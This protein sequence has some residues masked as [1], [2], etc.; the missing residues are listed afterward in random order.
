MIWILYGIQKMRY[1][2]KEISFI[3]LLILFIIFAIWNQQKNNYEIS[4]FNKETDTYNNFQNQNNLYFETLRRNYNKSN[5]KN[6]VTIALI[7]TGVDY[8]HEDLAGKIWTNKK[9][10]PD[11]FID[12]DNNGYI[13]DIYGWNFYDNTKN[14]FSGNIEDDH[15]TMTAGIIT[16]ND[17]QFGITGVAGIAD[18][19]IQ[20]LKVTSS[21]KICSTEKIIKAIQYAEENGA[22]ICNINISIS[23]KNIELQ[24][25]IKNSKMLFIVA[26]GNN[27][28]IGGKNIDKYPVFPASFKFDNLITVANLSIDGNLHSTSNYGKDSVDIAAPGDCIYSTTVNNKYAYNTGTSFSAPIVTGVAALLFATKKNLTA[29]DA[30][31]IIIDNSITKQ[32]LVNYIKDGKIL[33]EIN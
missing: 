17:N 9:E 24:K 8:N 15:G 14:V 18:I 27:N 4:N 3:F 25:Q 1:K 13:D 19:E 26:A 6:K 21:N 32:H 12:N 2:I 28:K 10:I 20:I 33:Y 31:K 5:I 16:A 29:P 23:E 30:K 7:D 11:D 22:Q